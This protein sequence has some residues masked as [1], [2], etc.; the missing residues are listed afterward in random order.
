[1]PDK[2]IGEVA[3]QCLADPAVLVGCPMVLGLIK[4]LI[5]ERNVWRNDIGETFRDFGIT[6]EDWR[7]ICSLI[8]D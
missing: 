7:K 1:M 3:R 2:E 8:P 4:K 5:E 6:A